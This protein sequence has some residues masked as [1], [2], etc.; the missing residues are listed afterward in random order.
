MSLGAAKGLQ[1]PFMSDPASL[2]LFLA[3]PGCTGFRYK[4]L[5]CSNYHVSKQNQHDAQT[6]STVPSYRSYVRTGTNYPCCRS[7]RTRARPSLSGSVSG[8][9]VAWWLEC[10]NDVCSMPQFLASSLPKMLRTSISATSRYTATKT[11]QSRPGQ[12][13]GDFVGACYKLSATQS[14]ALSHDDSEAHFIFSI[15]SHCF[16]YSSSRITPF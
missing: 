12:S 9:S 3:V 13:L 10:V 4:Q 2:I 8:S 14:R 11:R 15:L 7:I 16:A 6:V 1:P 5:I